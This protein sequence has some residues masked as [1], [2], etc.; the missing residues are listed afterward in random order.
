MFVRKLNKIQKIQIHERNA[1][2]TMKKTYQRFARGLAACLLVTALAAMPVFAGSIGEN[3][4]DTSGDN[5]V[6]INRFLYHLLH[7]HV[8][9]Y[10]CIR[11]SVNSGEIII[12]LTLQPYFSSVHNTGKAYCITSQTVERI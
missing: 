10:V 9:V 4:I 2:N 6:A 11:Y 1:N 7:F 12:V 3:G 8:F 5:I